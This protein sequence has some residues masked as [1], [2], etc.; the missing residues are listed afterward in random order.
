MFQFNEYLEKIELYEKVMDE[1]QRIVHDKGKMTLYGYKTAGAAMKAERK[2]EKPLVI[3]SKMKMG[4]K[5]IANKSGKKLTIQPLANK[6]MVNVY[7]DRG[8][9]ILYNV[10][11]YEY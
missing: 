10:Y 8:R 11:D 6:D 9:I 2:D 7:D 4:Q 3:V 5:I 1:I